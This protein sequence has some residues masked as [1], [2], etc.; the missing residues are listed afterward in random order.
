[1]S[2]QSV[3]YA[4]GGIPHAENPQDTRTAMVEA[5]TG[6]DGKVPTDLTQ[7]FGRSRRVYQERLEQEQA[8]EPLIEYFHAELTA[9]DTIYLTFFPIQSTY[10]NNIRI[11]EIFFEKGMMDEVPPEGMPRILHNSREDFQASLRRYGLAVE[12]NH[13]YI[14][15]GSGAKELAGQIK[16]LEYASKETM[17]LDILLN[18][19]RVDV[20]PFSGVSVSPGLTGKMMLEN[21]FRAQID[22]FAIIQ[23]TPL[24]NGFTALVDSLRTIHRSRAKREGEL[25]YMIIGQGA[26]KHSGQ[27]AENQLSVFSGKPKNAPEKMPDVMSSIDNMTIVESRQFAAEVSA[28]AYA[29]FML[30]ETSV[31]GFNVL[32]AYP[33]NKVYE[34]HFKTKFQSLQLYNEDRDLYSTITSQ[35]ALQYSGLFRYP[36][37]G[38]RKKSQFGKYMDIH[39]TPLGGYFF[40]AKPLRKRYEDSEEYYR[41]IDTS[42]AQYLDYVDTLNEFVKMMKALPKETLADL[43]YYLRSAVGSEVVGYREE[44][45]VIL[46]YLDDDEKEEKE[47]DN[48]VQFE[49]A[50]VADDSILGVLE[51]NTQLTD[52]LSSVVLPDDVQQKINR[53]DDHVRPTVQLYYSYL[54]LYEQDKFD[55]TNAQLESQS[56]SES[57]P[58]EQRLLVLVKAIDIL[59]RY[60]LDNNNNRSKKFLVEVVQT[61]KNS[62]LKKGKKRKGSAPQQSRKTRKT[63]G[64]VLSIANFRN[65]LFKTPINQ[66]PGLVNFCFDHDIPFPISFYLFRPH[67]RYLMSGCTSFVSGGK[68]GEFYIA[69]PNMDMGHDA[70]RKVDLLNFHVYFGMFIKKQDNVVNLRNVYCQDYLGGNGCEFYDPLEDVQDYL[71]GTDVG[72]SIFSIAEYPN[73]ISPETWY[74]DITGRMSGKIVRLV[75]TYKEKED[76]YSMAELYSNVWGWQRNHYNPAP[77]VMQHDPD[78]ERHYCTLVFAD[79]AVRYDYILRKDVYDINQGHWGQNIYPGCGKVRRGKD[80]TLYNAPY[81][82]PTPFNLNM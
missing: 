41:G 52:Q 24:G 72:K 36:E 58:T 63:S 51:R 79:H 81:N 37:T 26:L 76:H 60:R 69:K 23:K 14:Q 15:D 47:E 2:A 39:L 68:T 56:F 78:A 8:F 25:N 61:A 43:M 20:D 30:S 82:N 6:N 50:T 17:C 42:W 74:M 29:D 44:V 33:D 13:E 57:V 48:E 54:K 34:P 22:Q 19:I 35:T 27:R 71:E 66:T 75:P 12:V 16:Q 64:S 3:T 67:K 5:F 31:G 18:L 38:Y 28:G 73:K 49:E 77:S 9:K 70:V 55:S 40:L 11:R 80:V 45:D 53:L 21:L 10:H 4:T 46:E 32:D 65:L 1:M 62:V 7:L 59:L